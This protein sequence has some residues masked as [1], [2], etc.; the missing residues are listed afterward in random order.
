MVASERGIGEPEM[1]LPTSA[2]AAFEKA[3]HYFGVRA[4]R[5]PVADDCRARPGRDG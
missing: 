4:V 2:H 5:V 3:A 1:V